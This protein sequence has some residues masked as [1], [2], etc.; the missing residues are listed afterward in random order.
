MQK[1]NA[2]LLALSSSIEEEVTIDIDGTVIVGFSTVCPYKISAGSTYPVGLG[3]TF[4]DA[5][6]VSEVS[7][8]KYNL[9]RVGDTYK[10]VLFGR[11][12]NGGVDIGNGIKIDD[13]YFKEN[14][15]LESSFV[16]IIADRITVDFLP[17]EH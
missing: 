10:H 13:D 8:E 9:E 15:Y 11:V 1:Y 12:T 3:L 14:I 7:E 17:I 6:E 4:L 5:I 2:R 16:K